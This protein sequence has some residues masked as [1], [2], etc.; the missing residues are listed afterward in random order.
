MGDDFNK[1][2]VATDLTPA[3]I[4]EKIKRINEIVHDFTKEMKVIKQQKKD[5]IN[6]ALQ[7]IDH[8]KIQQIL[9]DINN[10]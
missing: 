7:R 10:N 2:L 8:Q 6:Q 5:V 4:E 3:Q 1:Q 9:Q